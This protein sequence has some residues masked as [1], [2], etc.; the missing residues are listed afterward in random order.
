V[1]ERCRVLPYFVERPATPPPGPPGSGSVCFVGRLARTKGVDVLIRAVRSAPSV[2]RLEVVGDGYHRAELEA[3]A[4]G[5]GIDV[6]FHGWLSP[7]EVR[8]V[9]SGVDVIAVPSV[10]PEP[11]GIVGLEAMAAGRAV[12]A[13]RIGGIPEWLDDGRTGTLVTPG[14][15]DELAAALEH[16]AGDPSSAARM[17]RTGWDRVARFGVD[18]HVRALLAIYED[19][20]QQ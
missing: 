1:R 19:A 8:A 3:L 9:M 15:V 17:G 12:V 2:R 13:S 11:F 10:W 6:R 20:Q 4:R 18:E 16:A 14:A 5:T 7:R